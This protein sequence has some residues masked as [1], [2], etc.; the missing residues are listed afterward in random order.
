V[1]TGNPFA[2]LLNAVF[3]NRYFHILTER[4]LAAGLRNYGGVT[5]LQLP[6]ELTIHG[7]LLQGLIGPVFLLSPL[8]LLALRRPAGR[9]ALLLAALVAIP[10]FVNHGARFLLPSLLFLALAL[11]IA[12]PRAVVVSL[13]LIHA[14]LSLPPMLALYAHPEAARL[15]GW[16]VRAA[17]RLEPEEEYLRRERPDT[18][19]AGLLQ[20]HVPPSSPV[21]DLYG[22]PEAYCDAV[23]IRPWQSASADRMSAALDLAANTGAGAF[24]DQHALWPA[25]PLTALRLRLGRAGD[26]GW[27]VQE[28]RL[29]RQGRTIARQPEW[30]VSS[31]PNIWESP[32][33]LDG[34]LAT[35]WAPWE[36]LQAGMY[37]QLNFPRPIVIDGAS[38]LVPTPEA[39]PDVEFLGRE[40]DGKWIR[41]AETPGAAP[42]PATDIRRSAIQLLKR[43]GVGFILA[44]VEHSVFSRLGTDLLRNQGEW[45]V[46]IAGSER[47]IYLFRIQ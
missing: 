19:L 27:G 13:A 41:L 8:A 17:L 44:P 20:Q 15:E 26:P 36:A 2:P 31:W 1:W 4:E 35:G 38:A 28:L 47:G 33:A 21:L 40:P 16:P 23:A 3:E 30:T 14:F 12:L 11:A 22:A 6:A 42:Q 7:F 25:R 10:W 46:E 45:G 39:Q 24:T 29:R 34:N 5:W 18:V 43:E 37:L 9:V 32:L